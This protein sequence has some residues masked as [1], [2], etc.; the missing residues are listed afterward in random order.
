MIIAGKINSLEEWFCKAPPKKRYKHWKDGHSAKEFAKLWFRKD[1]NKAEV[2]AELL[3][4]IKKQFSDINIKF[5]IPEHITHIDTFQGGQR[6]HDLCLFGSTGYGE[7]VIC[8]E[9]KATESLGETIEQNLE[10]VK[11]KKSS[12]LPKR[13]N[14]LSK[15]IFNSIPKNNSALNQI[16]YQLL[17]GLYGTLVEGFL[18]EAKNAMFIVH[19][20]C[21][22]LVSKKIEKKTFEDTQYFLRFIPNIKSGQFKEGQPIGLIDYKV[23]KKYR[24]KEKLS[25]YFGY[26]KTDLRNK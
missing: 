20:I 25:L 12:N 4:L 5:G 10:A 22:N 21:T 14:T 23:P 19:Q 17:T 26:V 6:N 16:Q 15:A 7:V 9:A 11:N 13:I 8:I 2:P 18:Q 24:N 1:K 3:N